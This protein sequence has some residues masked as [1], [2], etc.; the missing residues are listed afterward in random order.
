MAEKTISVWAASPANRARI[1]CLTVQRVSGA[2]QPAP[3][4]TVYCANLLGNSGRNSF[5]GPGLTT[6][7][8]SIF[9]NTHVPKISETISIQFRAEFFNILNHTNLPRPIS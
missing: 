5:Y 7:D 1:V 9:K 8:F 4:G 3:G 6:V 2:A